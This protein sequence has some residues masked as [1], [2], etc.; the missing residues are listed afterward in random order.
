[1]TVFHKDFDA[2]HRDMKAL[3][4]RK[5]EAKGWDSPEQRQAAEMAVCALWTLANNRQVNKAALDILR[6]SMAKL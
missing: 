2:L 4:A 3:V 1:M 5:D 6:E